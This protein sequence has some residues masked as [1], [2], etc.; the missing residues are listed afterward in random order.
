MV[1]NMNLGFLVLEDVSDGC[2]FYKLI[3]TFMWNYIF[4]IYNLLNGKM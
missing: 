4:Y 2:D 3:H 1:M